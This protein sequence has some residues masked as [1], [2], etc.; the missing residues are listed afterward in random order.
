MKGFDDIQK[1]SKDNIEQAM[2]SVEAMSKG[3]QALAVETADYQKKSYETG[4][5]AI[6]KI[7]AAKSVE[8]A[9][10]IQ[11]EYLKATYEGYISELS[12]IGSMMTDFAKDAYR[13]FESVFGKI[14]K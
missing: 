10:E 13:P 1:A 6:E 5:A 14:P 4:A 7:V 8:K 9:V 2:K 12:K 3:I 11:N